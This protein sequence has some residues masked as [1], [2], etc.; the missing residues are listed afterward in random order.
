MNTRI[1]LFYPMSAV[2]NLFCGILLDPN[3]ATV[4]DD[5]HL[6]ER[7]PQ[8]LRKISKQIETIIEESYLQ[9]IEGFI[10]ELV[11]LGRHAAKE[12]K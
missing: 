8:L 12:A 11:H 3:N 10:S 6:I 4:Q 1:I 7:T 2:L 9:S 5:I